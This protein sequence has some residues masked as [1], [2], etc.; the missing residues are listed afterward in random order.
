MADM[1]IMQCSSCAF[2]I[3]LLLLSSSS[4]SDVLHILISV[5]CAFLSV[6]A[7]VLYMFHEVSSLLFPKWTSIGF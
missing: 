7:S 4:R 2:L 5:S 6:C 3:R 1:A